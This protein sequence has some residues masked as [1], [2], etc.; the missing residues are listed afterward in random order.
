[1]VSVVHAV[2]L[3]QGDMRLVNYKQKVVAEKVKEA[4]W[5]LS[6]RP[7]VKVPRVVFYPGAISKLLNH[8]KVVLGSRCEPL[9][10]K[11]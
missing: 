10:L 1:M 6:G 11:F 5:R 3:R 8:F 4:K 2:K 7:A 9:A